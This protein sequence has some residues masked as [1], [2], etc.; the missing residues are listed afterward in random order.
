MARYSSALLLFFLVVYAAL[1]DS[2]L[3]GRRLLNVKQIEKRS[4]PALED[5]MILSALPKSPVP[6]STPSKK[7][8]SVVVD[9]KL[10]ARRLIISIDRS[11]L[12]SVPSP[13]VGN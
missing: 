1:S 5:S 9:D 12:R 11:T 3:E 4:I 10:I 8:H 2:C 6:S 13:G 7:G